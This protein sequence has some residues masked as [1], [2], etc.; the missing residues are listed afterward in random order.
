M[1]RLDEEGQERFEAALANVAGYLGDDFV[2][3]GLIINPLLLAWDAAHDIDAAVAVPLEELLTGII[4]RASVQRKEILEV[5]DEV[6][7]LAVSTAVLVAAGAIPV[8]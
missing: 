3:A 6:R 8:P 4:H 2:P 5:L 7:A 1:V